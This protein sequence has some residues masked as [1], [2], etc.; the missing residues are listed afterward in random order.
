MKKIHWILLIVALMLALPAT[1]FAGGTALER[2][3]NA[4]WTCADIAGAMHCFDPGDGKSKNAS[5]INVKVYDYDGT[6]LGT[7]QLWSVDVYAGQPCPQDH[8]IDLGDHIACHRY[9]D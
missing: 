6:F 2:T 4:G 7:E 8:L 1:V 3:E 5:S 9:S